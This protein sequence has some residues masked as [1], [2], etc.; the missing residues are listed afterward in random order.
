MQPGW[1]F[2]KEPQTSSDLLP[3]PPP[4]PAIV[5]PNRPDIG[6]ELERSV[7]SGVPSKRAEFDDND[8]ENGDSHDD[9]P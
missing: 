9:A 6:D 8:V 7:E 5:I 1:K 4:T 2:H 3:A